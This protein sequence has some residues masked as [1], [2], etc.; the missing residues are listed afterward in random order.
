MNRHLGRNDHTTA[1]AAQNRSMA[2]TIILTMP[3]FVAFL[4]IPEE[5]M[6]GVFM[7]GRFTAADARASALVLAAYGIGI[8]PVVLIRSLVA[9]FHA[10]QD[11]MTPLISAFIGIAIN[12]VLKIALYQ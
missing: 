8:L 4:S 11:T 5:I 9:S 6:R 7:H 2:L 1:H 10:R 12:V 3:F